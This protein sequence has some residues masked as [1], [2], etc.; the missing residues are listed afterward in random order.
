MLSLIDNALLQGLTHAPAVLGVAIA[1]RVLRYPDLTADG[2]FLLGSTL[3]AA[4]AH[5]GAT[6]AVSLAVAV[7]FGALAGITTGLLS[8][9]LRVNRLLSGILTSMACYS[10]G[11]R[12][13]GR[14]PNLGLLDQRTFFTGA[15][16]FDRAFG[17]G[18]LHP[19]SL[20]LCAVL[21][22]LLSWAILSLL[23]SDLG[24]VLRAAGAN[25][26]LTARLGRSPNRYRIVGLG[27]ANA[28]VALSAAL[29]TMRQGF[30]DV[31]IGTGIVVVLIACL[32]MGEETLRV[33]KHDPTAALGARVAAPAVGAVLYFALFLLVV[34]ASSR[35]WLPIQL[36]PTDLTFMS[37]LLIV[38]VYL[39][40]LRTQGRDEL[41]PL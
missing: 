11:F 40:R 30:A 38:C 1:F 31:N 13:L 9:V 26:P 32:V 20:G 35:G 14:R 24:I 34:R 18:V 16:S 6:P 15:D 25:E 7:L 41:L 10:L 28:L 17:G 33:M 21:V 8:A 23:R 27:L 2:S 29:V 39:S 5:A 12:I 3:V 36:E 22:A 19:A 4:T 37:A